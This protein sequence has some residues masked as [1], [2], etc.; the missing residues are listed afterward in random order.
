MAGE[1]SISTSIGIRKLTL[2]G[3]AVCSQYIIVHFVKDAHTDNVGPIEATCVCLEK[4][5]GRPIQN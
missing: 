3:A 2:L 1:R 4:D 5:T